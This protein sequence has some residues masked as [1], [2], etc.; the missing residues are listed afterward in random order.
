MGALTKLAPTRSSVPVPKASGALLTMGA[1]IEP[2]RKAADTQG[3]LRME[4][5]LIV[6]VFFGPGEVPVYEAFSATPNQEKAYSDEAIRLAIEQ[7][8]LR[9]PHATRV[10]VYKPIEEAE[11]HATTEVHIDWGE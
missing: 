8:V 3:R 4:L 2:E 7:A 6:K 11:V 10:R 1:G 5:H 9:N